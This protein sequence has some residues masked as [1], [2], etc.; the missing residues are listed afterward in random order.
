MVEQLHGGSRVR[1]QSVLGQ[2]PAHFAGNGTMNPELR[3]IASL[4]GQDRPA[5]HRSY[6]GRT[7]DKGSRCEVGKRYS[8]A[9][10]YIEMEVQAKE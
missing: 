1:T 4:A 7:T 6:G 9:L 10:Q 2:N 8:L 3:L 5:E